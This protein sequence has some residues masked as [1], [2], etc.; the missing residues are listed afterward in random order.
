MEG[1]K[2]LGRGAESD[3]TGSVSC[4]VGGCRIQPKCF[5]YAVGPAKFL[6]DLSRVNGYFVYIEY[7][8]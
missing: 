3:N 7:Q 1:K 8:K 4:V 6:L 2:E 5:E